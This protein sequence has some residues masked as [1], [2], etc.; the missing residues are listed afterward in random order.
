MICL[1]CIH[2]TDCEDSKL[3]IQDCGDYKSNRCSHMVTK[4]NEDFSMDIC[5]I[6][7]KPCLLQDG[8]TCETWEQ[9][10]AEDLCFIAT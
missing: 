9:E 3:N 2:R 7:T 10:K 4:G 1:S 6:N 8:S 5:D